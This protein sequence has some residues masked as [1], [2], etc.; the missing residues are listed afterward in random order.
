MFTQLS[1]WFSQLDTTMQVFW[2]C[3]IA[4]SVVFVIQNA[5]MLLGIG[6]MDADVDADVGTDFDVHG[7]FD[8]SDADLDLSTGHSGHE[9]TLG[10]AGIF[11]LFTLR[12]FINFFLG[13]GWGGISLSPVVPNKALLVFFSFL[14]GLV[15]VA[16]FV[17]MLRAM[18]KLERNGNFRITECIGQT[19]SVYLRIPAHRE[20]AGKI[21]I[22]INGSVHELNAF[23][24][25]DFLPTGTRIRV[26]EIIDSGSVLVEKESGH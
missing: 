21:Q 10:S 20:G 26:T 25:G 13:F 12:N 5:L 6:G 16:V 9:G 19:A 11:S 17:L 22:S 7:D 2:T 4:A 24:D 14:T 23:T 15:F 1:T 3:A 8:A 18:L